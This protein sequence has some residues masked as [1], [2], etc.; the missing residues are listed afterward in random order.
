MI[1]LLTGHKAKD[2]YLKN[3]S[4][5]DTENSLTTSLAE[6]RISVLSTGVST[7]GRE[8]VAGTN[9][10]YNHVYSLVGYDRESKLFTVVDPNKNMSIR[11]ESGDGYIRVTASQIKE[12]F[13]WSY[14]ETDEDIF[15]SVFSL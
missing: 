10:S 6:K 3:R 15:W 13:A 4:V 5:A 12:L 8:K 2:T 11:P 7:D 14:E 1:E 9:L